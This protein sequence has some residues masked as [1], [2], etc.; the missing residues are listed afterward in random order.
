MEQGSSMQETIEFRSSSSD[1]SSMAK[2]VEPISGSS[3][4]FTLGICYPPASVMMRRLRLK[5]RY[6]ETDLLL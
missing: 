4:L 3:A 2:Y 1:R 5:K 6:R